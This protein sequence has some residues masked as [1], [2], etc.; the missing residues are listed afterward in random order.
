MPR[1][2][3]VKTWVRESLQDYDPEIVYLNPNDYEELRRELE[4]QPARVKGSSGARVRI[5]GVHR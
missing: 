2:D 5:D 1:A 3:W 4:I